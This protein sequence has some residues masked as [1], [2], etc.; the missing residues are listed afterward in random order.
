MLCNRC[1]K[2]F[3]CACLCFWPSE[4]C[5]LVKRGDEKEMCGPVCILEQVPR[6]ALKTPFRGG[7][8]QDIA[9]QVWTEGY[10][11]FEVSP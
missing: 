7:T 10:T 2:R 8:L 4:L 5:S 1:D 9:K 6:Q 11:P 3:A